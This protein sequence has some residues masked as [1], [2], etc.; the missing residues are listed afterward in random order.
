MLDGLPTDQHLSVTG[1][2]VQR[3]YT[4]CQDGA[5]YT[6]LKEGFDGLLDIVRERYPGDFRTGIYEMQFRDIANPA[7]AQQHMHLDEGK[8]FKY[9]GQTF[10][11]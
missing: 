6:K 7:C 9:E 3:L 8:L 2:R 5:V 1:G 10:H 4:V 11:S